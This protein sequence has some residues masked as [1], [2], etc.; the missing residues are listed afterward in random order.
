MKKV[1]SLLLVLCMVFAL[2]ACG[3]KEEAAAPAKAADAPAAEAPAVDDTVYTL[4]FYHTFAGTGQE[5]EWIMKAAEEIS[6]QTN[7]KVVLNVVP[8]G[9]MG[10]EDETIPQVMAGSLDMSL[11]G[12]SV[13]GTNAGIT[14]LDWSEYPYVVTNYSEMNALGEILPAITNKQLEE[15]GVEQLY[16]LGAMSQGIRCLC[17]IDPVN[18]MADAK[19]LK[20]RVPTSNVYEST[21]AAFGCS[22]T[23]MSSS[24]VITGLAN[25]T[26]DGFESDPGSIIPR[27]QQ[28]SFNYY[29]ETN[30]IASLNLLMINKAKL[31]SLPVEYQDAI[32]TVFKDICVQQCYDR[33]D[34]NNELT[35]V[36]VDAGVEVVTLAPEV[37]E[38]FRA[39]AYAF[40]A[41]MIEKEGVQSYVDEAMAYV[42]ANAK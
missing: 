13:W 38:E 35:Q 10:G 8:D 24:Q 32:K 37:F 1:V 4:N 20:I 21:V 12:P 7:G 28:E 19:G 22:P 33:V 30:H 42:A 15:L 27:G 31:E 25:K 23:A 26:I 14:A 39:A 2:C 6:A 16:C 17:T 34:Y 40:S 11:S 5:Q 9:T 36:M 41:E 3:A 29:T 18:V